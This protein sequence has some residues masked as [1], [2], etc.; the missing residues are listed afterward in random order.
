V[1]FDIVLLTAVPPVLPYLGADAEEQSLTWTSIVNATVVG[2]VLQKTAGFDGVDDAGAT[3]QQQ[4]T[5]GDGT[6]SLPWAK[7][8]PSGSAD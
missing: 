6:C 2:N 7:R 5:A 8:T 1:S 4:L 3:S